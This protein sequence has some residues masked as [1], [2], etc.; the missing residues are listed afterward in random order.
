MKHVVF[1]TLE[2]TVLGRPEWQDFK[3]LHEDTTGPMKVP[4]FDGKNRAEH[5]FKGL[6][7]TFMLTSC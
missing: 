6:P 5:L 7:V 4:H 2:D 1:T 3:V